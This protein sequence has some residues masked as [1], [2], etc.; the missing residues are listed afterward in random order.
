MVTRAPRAAKWR[1][2]ASPMPDPPPVTSTDI[3]VIVLTAVFL[4]GLIVVQGRI[5][6][7]YNEKPTVRII[8]SVRQG[9]RAAA[10]GRGRLER[11]K[12]GKFPLALRPQRWFS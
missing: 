8:F 9:R 7:Q 1:A 5:F 12:P 10:V 2:T 6:L 4:P 11:A 3:P